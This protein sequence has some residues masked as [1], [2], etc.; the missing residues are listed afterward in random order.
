MSNQ[1]LVLNN[2]GLGDVVMSFSFFENILQHDKFSTILVMFKSD[3]E[4]ELFSFTKF[5]A[6]NINRFRLYCVKDIGKLLFYTFRIKK[7]FSLG[8][9]RKKSIKLFKIL[10]IKEYYLACPYEYEKSIKKNILHNEDKI[11]KSILY[12]S[13]FYA[14][15]NDISIQ[16]KDYFIDFN[17]NVKNE[18]Y[19]VFSGGS[20]ELEKHKRW[21]IGGYRELLIKIIDNMH[22]KIVFVGS[23]SE[24][25]IV[26]KI[27][28]GL[29]KRY[30]NK[31]IQL[32]GKTNLKE[33]INVLRNAELVIG[34][35]NGVL[36][37]ASACN[38]KILGLFGSTDF[39]ITG[40]NGNFVNIIDNRI[41]CAPCYAKNGNIKGCEDNIC[42]KSIDYKDVYKEVSEIME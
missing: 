37:I 5:Y 25:E 6:E 35:D 42:M 1:I 21:T 3:L 8:V 39:A 23:K 28:G 17:N 20:G 30:L 19:I 41:E 27:L 32:N 31:T 11:H 15:D 18:N 24:Q 14:F 13:L 29:D 33:L 9:N 40:P 4:K 16:Y 7:A 26:S 34:N 10:A 12:A 38:S 2:H 36:H 22:L